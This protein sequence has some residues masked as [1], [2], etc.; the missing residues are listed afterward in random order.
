MSN[1]ATAPVAG[2]AQRMPKHMIIQE[3]IA[4][5]YNTL[6]SLDVLIREIQGPIP[7]AVEK[8]PGN[9]QEANPS[10]GRFLDEVPGE[11]GDIE[12]KLHEKI[13]FLR[14]LIL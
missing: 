5:L 7:E 4:N 10:L 6:D 2:A 3:K 12:H 14:D 1:L 11:L 8:P 9:I 13:N